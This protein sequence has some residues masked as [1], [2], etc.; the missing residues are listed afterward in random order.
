MSSL[1]PQIGSDRHIEEETLPQYDPEEFYPVRIGQTL[2]SRY[3]VIGKLGYGA[4][5]TVWFCRDLN[6]A[7]YVATKVYTRTPPGGTNRE[8]LLYE[9]CD[10]TT[11]THPG[12]L[13]VRPVLDIFELVRKN[14]D[15]HVCL[16]LPPLQ[17]TLFAFQRLG[18]RPAPLPEEVAK[19]CIR[20]LLESLDFLHTEIG[21]THCDIK[22]SNLMFQVEDESIFPDYEE[23]EKE[24][25]SERK[26]IN[27]ERSIYSS[28]RFRQPR[29]HA[30]GLPVLCDFGEARIGSSHPWANIQPEVYRAPEI[31]MQFEHYDC[32]IDIWNLWN[33]LEVDHL[34]DGTDE[35]GQHNNRLHMHEIVSLLSVP[36]F[37]FLRRSPQTW[38][39]FDEFGIGLLPE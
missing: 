25:P 18:G 34:L 8:K 28:R 39:L 26:V 10:K 11:T 9:Q 30:Y 6:T 37:E 17:T 27:E 3:N 29:A 38:R 23:A 1:A 20:S 4:N 7:Q 19:V 14:G 2:D 31:L 21:V 12:A 32:A 16:I 35:E 24:S 5:S 33:M 36:P 22:L 13:C 15:V